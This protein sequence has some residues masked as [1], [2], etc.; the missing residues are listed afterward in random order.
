M[1]LAVACSRAH[2]GQPGAAVSSAVTPAPQAPAARTCSVTRVVDQPAFAR[3]KALEFSGQFAEAAEAM[4]KA[5]GSEAPRCAT[6]FV[7]GRLL[8]AAG[9]ASKAAA[10]FADVRGCAL[11]PYAIVRG[12]AELIKSGQPAEAAVRLSNLSF[13][14]TVLG[15]EHR[16][17]LGEAL[18]LKGDRNAAMSLWRGTLA[19][20]PRGHRWV[21][22]SVKLATALLDDPEG[23]NPERLREALDLVTRVYIE[24]PKLADASGAT[25][26][27]QRA[28]SKLGVQLD[29]LPIEDALRRAQAWLDTGEPRQAI[30]ELR[31]LDAHRLTEPRASCRFRTL[32]AQAVTKTKGHAADAWGEAIASCTND[33][34]ALALYSGAKASASEKKVDEALERWARL[35]REFPRHRL[36]DDA[37]FLS[38][39]AL[40]DRGDKGDKGDKR[41]EAEFLGRLRSLPDDYPEGDMRK[42]ALF[43][44]ALHGMTKGTWDAAQ[45]ALERLADMTDGDRH[46]AIAGRALYFRAR[47]ASSLGKTAEA[48]ELYARVIREYPLA[49]YMTQAYARLAADDAN[50]ARS[51]LAAATTRDTEA[52]QPP[53]PEPL[54]APAFARAQALL[55]VGEVDAARKEFARAEAT[56]EGAPDATLLCV[57]RSYNEGGAPE[58]GHVLGKRLGTQL[59]RYPTSSFRRAWETAF[60]Q[61]FAPAVTEEASRHQIPI[62]L[63]WAIMRE[64]SNFVV[65][66]KSPARAFGLMQLIV[67]TASMVARGTKH[68]SDEQALVRAEVS[69]ALGT[70][71]LGQLRRS[72]PQHPALAIAAYNAGSGAVQKWLRAHPG[73]DFDLWVEQIPYEET[74]NYVKRVLASQAAYAYL[75][76]P[77][78]LEEVFHLPLRVAP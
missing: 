53:E 57:G 45:P 7:H 22:T 26:A 48:R 75:Y 23:P 51:V 11:E 31:A 39:I 5:R 6:T 37:R 24:A 61:A 76:E 19:A 2:P 47:A 34:L 60:P 66:A 64:E 46:W 40:R 25:A 43:R 62:S 27:R 50:E 54:D 17:L 69:I 12:A 4:Q 13:D 42:E 59:G 8:S 18:A 74:R 78:A 1:A 35:E 56:K 21:D 16:V 73:A 28:A 49:F 71:L 68:P 3:V 67:P 10:T 36:A 63:A 20:H 15:D 9:D 77:K 29:A 58:F 38:A 33:E 65:D 30:T 44:V 55:E 72:L 14:A 70:K 52:P 41:D 32:R